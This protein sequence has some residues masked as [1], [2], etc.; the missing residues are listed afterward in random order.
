MLL[1]TLTLLLST[2]NLATVA[3][4]TQPRQATAQHGLSEYLRP[5]EAVRQVEL[6][7][8]AHRGVLYGVP[9]TLKRLI[10]LPVQDYARISDRNTE[11]IENLY[12]AIDA[13]SVDPNVACRESRLDV[14]WAIVLT[15]TDGKSD[16]VGIG[17]VSPCI[18]LSS[19]EAPLSASRE[20]LLNFIQRTLPFTQSDKGF[21]DF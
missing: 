2:L 4:A 3:P 1:T 8:V 18:Q 17:L 14:R 9:I 5:A 6:Y 20:Q 13:T 19:Q 12:R 15:Y 21:L 10:E 7:H 11:V 16:A